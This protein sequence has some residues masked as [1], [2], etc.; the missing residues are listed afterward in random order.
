MKKR[1]TKLRSACRQQRNRLRFRLALPIC[2]M[3]GRRHVHCSREDIGG[4]QA[5][6]HGTLETLEYSG[7]HFFLQTQEARVVADI[8]ARLDMLRRGA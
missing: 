4:W 7:G 8:R 6:T 3:S 2:G 5:H 1:M